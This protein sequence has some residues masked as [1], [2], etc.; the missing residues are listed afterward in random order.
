MG[1]N[2]KKGRKPFLNC[3]TEYRTSDIFRRVFETIGAVHSRVFENDNRHENTR[4][5]IISLKNIDDFSHSTRKHWSVEN[6]LHW[7]LDVIFREDLSKAKKD[8]SPLNLNVL[9]K[10]A[11]SLLK[12]VDSGSK[13]ICL[14]KKIFMLALDYRLFEKFI[15][16]NF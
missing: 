16:E 5:F 12:N 8:N 1:N 15:F 3:Q 10:L 2:T 13:R 14:E 9:R 11:L 4:Y 6:N 7:C